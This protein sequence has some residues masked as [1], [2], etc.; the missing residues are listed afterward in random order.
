MSRLQ[1]L[2]IGIVGACGRG[3]TFAT[4]LG[5]RS[6]QVCVQAVCDT[7]TG[8]LTSSGEL[9]GASATYTDYEDMLEAGSL[10]AVM[11]ATPMHLHAPQ[12]IMALEA[13]LHVLCEVTPAVSIEECRQLVVA[14]RRARGHYMLAENCNY[15]RQSLLVEELV[16]QGLFGTPY[17]AEA[18]YLHEVRDLNERTRWRRRWQTG[19]D[20]ITYGTH[21]LGPVLSWMPGERVTRVCCAGSGHH[22]QDPRGDD[23]HQD[24]H[25]MLAQTGGG[26]LIK[27]RL[28]MVSSRPSVTTTY[29]LQGTEG[30]FE[31]ARRADEQDR[32]WLSSIH[33][34]PETWGFLKDLESQYLPTRWR[35]MFNAV[36]EAGHGGTDSLMSLAFLDAVLNDEPPPIDIDRAMDMSLPCLISQTSME[37]QGS[38]LDVPDSRNWSAGSA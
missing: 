8:A 18:E 36:G 5:Q 37:Q 24:T 11:I 23:Y 12:S 1:A 10:D 9:F 22:Y 29:Q 7:N 16:R 26:G 17:F 27:I 20:G 3:S 30:C 34:G 2:H 21:A 14:A 38:W 28:D 19:I 35:E 15:R 33:E 31:S 25:V 13:G 4:A 32:I 6:E